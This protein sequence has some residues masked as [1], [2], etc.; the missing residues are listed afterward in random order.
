MVIF[1]NKLSIIY[2]Q[3]KKNFLLISKCCKSSHIF[4]VVYNNSYFVQHFYWFISEIVNALKS[5]ATFL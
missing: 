1:L 3:K 2:E 5:W 4:E